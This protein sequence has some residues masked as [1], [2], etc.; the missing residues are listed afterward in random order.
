[1]SE[2]AHRRYH[3]GNVEG[4]AMT[5]AVWLSGTDP[6]Q[7]LGSRLESASDRKSRLFAVACCRRIQHA[8]PDPEGIET[9]LD[10]AE[11]YAD[12]FATVQELRSA[13]FMHLCGG[14]MSFERF[15]H[16]AAH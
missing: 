12:G 16:E 1:M 9:R 7:M 10:I 8:M 5:E 6:M 14:G 15:G 11:R 3:R 4:R 2:Q 13:Q